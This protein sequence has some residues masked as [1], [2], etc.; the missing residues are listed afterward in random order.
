MNWKCSRCESDNSDTNQWCKGCRKVRR[1]QQDNSGPPPTPSSAASV[2]PEV[3][4]PT[5]EQDNPG[6]PPTPS[7]ASVAP[8]VNTASEEQDNSG[9]P[10]TPSFA[11]SVGPEVNTTTEEQDNSG[12]PPTPSS[13]ASALPEVRAAP[14]RRKAAAKAAERMPSRSPAMAACSTESVDRYTSAPLPS[15]PLMINY[16]WMGSGALSPKDKFNIYSWRALGHEVNICAFHPSSTHTFESLGLE[17]GDATVVDLRELLADDDAF[18]GDGDDPRAILSE[19]RALLLSWLDA[20]PDSGKIER[21]HLY[22]MID[23]TKSYLGCTR[24]GIVLDLKVGPST[25][26]AAYESVFQEMFVSYSRGGNTAG[27]RPENQC[28]GTMQETD[29]LRC[30]YA[31]TFEQNI[32]TNLEGLKDHNASWFNAITGYHGRAWASTTSPIDVVTTSPDQR[33]ISEFEVKEMGKNFGPFRVF[34]KPGDQTN[35]AAGGTSNNDIR[36]LCR[37]VFN[38][39]LKNSGGDEEFLRKA[40]GAMDEL[41]RDKLW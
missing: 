37:D 14:S 40:K 22:N 5:D 36:F 25:H 19:T 41:P 35:K 26:V 38:D 18:D 29:E 31:R 1:P 39:E 21:E 9:S 11:A 2:T 33:D 12:S 34:K 30:E 16:V 4:T 28:M 17:E 6:P 10:P 20:V 15:A 24:R 7:S 3:N 32:I 13:A 27:G 23:L 8:V